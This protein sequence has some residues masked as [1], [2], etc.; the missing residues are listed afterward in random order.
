MVVEDVLRST[1]EDC[2]N[3][4]WTAFQQMQQLSLSTAGIMQLNAYFKWTR[5]V[6]NFQLLA[7]IPAFNQLLSPMLTL[8][9]TL[10]TSLPTFTVSSRESF[11]TH[12]MAEYVKS[13][14]SLFSFF[15]NHATIN[16]LN[17]RELCNI[18]NDNNAPDVIKRVNNVI[19]W[20]REINE[21]YLHFV[22]TQVNKLNGDP[23]GPLPN[24]YSDMM[25]VLANATYDDES[26]VPG[27]IGKAGKE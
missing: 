12:M 24:S 20:V 11:N 6:S 18:M 22:C 9:T 16:G 14:D 27:D 19:N 10:T 17:V 7:H 8:N 13:R 4:T 3:N 23:V 26:A 1:S 2:W 25:K 15:Q 5:H 21:M